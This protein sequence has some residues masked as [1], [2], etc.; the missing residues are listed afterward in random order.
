MSITKKLFSLSLTNAPEPLEVRW[1]LGGS[2][3]E[4]AGASITPAIS[5]RRLA[6]WI[7]GS[8]FGFGLILWNPYVFKVFF[9][10]SPCIFPCI[11]FYMSKRIEK[12]AIFSKLKTRKSETGI[13]I[14][15]RSPGWPDHKK[16]CRT[17]IRIS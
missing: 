5:F 14:G 9:N 2:L 12:Y 3:P 7:S 4:P 16:Y 1:V 13:R 6:G 10:N 8:R 17:L 11:S 15:S